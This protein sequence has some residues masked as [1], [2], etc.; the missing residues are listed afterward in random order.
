MFF[1]VAHVLHINCF[2][3]MLVENRKKKFN[4]I[5]YI[6]NVLISILDCVLLFNFFSFVCKKQKR[7]AGKRA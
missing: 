4:V 6:Y 7:I 2:A 3:Y 5:K 1:F